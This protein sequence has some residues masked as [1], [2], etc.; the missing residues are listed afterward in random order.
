MWSAESQYLKKKK[1]IVPLFSELFVNS[2]G[3]KAQEN[4]DSHFSHDSEEKETEEGNG[5]HFC[6]VV[7]TEQPMQKVISNIQ[8]QATYH[9]VVLKRTSIIGMI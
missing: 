1:K 8:M 4:Q 7:Y 3:D 2:F 9:L 6:K 5:F